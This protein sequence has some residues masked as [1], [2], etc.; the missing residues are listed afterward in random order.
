MVQ[1]YWIFKLMDITSS[2][3]L[4][5]LHT[6]WHYSWGTIIHLNSGICEDL[7]LRLLLPLLTSLE[8]KKTNYSKTCL[9]RPLK[10]K[11]KIGF[12]YQIS[13][14]AGQKCCRMPKGD[15]SAVLSTFIKLPFSFNKTCVLSIFKL[16]LKTGFT[17]TVK[18]K[19]PKCT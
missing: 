9:K 11:T 8:N 12:Q 6:C 7:L 18:K 16:P 19:R 4:F 15:H 5:Q 3:S 13:L 2:P 17:V 1:C 14:N 10:K